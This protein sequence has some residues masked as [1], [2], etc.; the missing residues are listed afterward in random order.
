[1][2]PLVTVLDSYTLSPKATAG[3]EKAV[4]RLEARK[5]RTRM[6]ARGEVGRRRLTLKPQVKDG[7]WPG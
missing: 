6:P 4:R 1:V 2:L 3:V 5:T 7:A